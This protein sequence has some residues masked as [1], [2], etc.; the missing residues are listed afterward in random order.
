MVKKDLAAESGAVELYQ[1]IL[2]KD[3]DDPIKMIV[4]KLLVSEKSH[5]H[6]FS[7]LLSELG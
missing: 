1:Q 5:H 2:E 4:E 3:F 7:K 6:Y